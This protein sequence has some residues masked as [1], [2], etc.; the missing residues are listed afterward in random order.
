MKVLMR[1]KHW[2]VSTNQ[3]YRHI[4]IDKAVVVFMPL[5]SRSEELPTSALLTQFPIMAQTCWPWESKPHVGEHG[6]W[7][8]FSGLCMAVVPGQGQAPMRLSAGQPARPQQPIYR[9]DSCAYG[10]AHICRV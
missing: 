7:G 4:E 2:P 6:R 10:G 8:R 3:L 9:S 1:F 5:N